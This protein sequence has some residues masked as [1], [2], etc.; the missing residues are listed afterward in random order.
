MKTLVLPELY[1]P[2]KEFCLAE[3]TEIGYGGAVG[4]GKSHVARIKMI[5]LA[6]EYPGIQ[7][8]LIR[9]TLGELRG[10]HILPLME[11][12]QTEHPDKNQR[13]AIYRDAKKEFMFPN[14]SRIELGYCEHEMDIYR[15]QGQ[16]FDVIFMEEAALLWE[17]VYHF[18]KSRN[19]LSGRIKGN[20]AFTPRMYFTFNPG[21]IGHQWV[22]AKF[23][24]NPLVNVE[25]SGIVFIQARVTDNIFLMENDP[26]YVKKLET[27]PEKQKRALLYGDW[28]AFEGQFF[29]EWDESKHVIE[30]FAIP[31]HWKRFRVRDYGFDML[32]TYWIALD[33][34]ANGYV[35]KELYEANLVVSAAARKI[36]EYTN[37]NIYLDI[38]PPDLW[39]RSQD[40]G[41]SPADT[42]REF[43]HNLV[44]ADNKRENGWLMMR[45]WLSD[46]EE[47]IVVDGEVRIIK[48]P[49]LRFFKT[50][51]NAIRTIPL[52]VFD[53]KN[54]NDCLKEP[55][56]IT[57]APDAIRYFCTSWT[58]A[59]TS[60]NFQ[61]Q[62]SWI[63]RA[64]K[65][66]YQS[67]YNKGDYI[68]W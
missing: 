57:H 11:I 27:L 5:L 4:G 10:N 58:F 43:G 67:K 46:V 28:N 68:I 24:D 3:G 44:K 22:K 50:C 32:A 38:A 49:K 54:P 65:E 17:S 30:P 37:E 35:Y 40:T 21:G 16:S 7:I 61:E 26:E 41:K 33:E 8:L 9:K 63:D 19:R 64:I 48:H 36:N 6:L 14:G 51:K 47:Q 29:E 34:K 66:K 52:L 39:S 12:L 45:D 18:L 62:E 59:P 1:P 31:Q 15:Y 2:Q 56:E 53:P 23:I 13:F 20:K 25:G 55:H 60:I 42:F